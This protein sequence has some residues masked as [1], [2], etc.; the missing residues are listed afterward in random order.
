[1]GVA[2]KPVPPYRCVMEVVA[3]TTPFLASSGPFRVLMVRLVVLKL[4][5]VA[6]VE[7]EFTVVK[8]VMVLVLEFTRI[9]PGIV[10]IPELDSDRRIV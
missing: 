2:V 8:S 4:V 10:A 9:P 5:V 1:M 7:V 6:E 3:L